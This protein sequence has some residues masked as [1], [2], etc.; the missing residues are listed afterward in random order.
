C[1]FA[2]RSVYQFGIK[3]NGLNVFEERI[4]CFKAKDF[5]E[6]HIKADAESEKY[7]NENDFIVHPEQI[8]YKQ[9]GNPLMDGYE[10]WSE[11]FESS[12]SLEDFYQDRYKKYEY[13]P[14]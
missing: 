11:L 1:W 12:K 2:I 7:A 6:A 3:E 8:G 14:E 9:D 13:N 5:D 4:V 10:L